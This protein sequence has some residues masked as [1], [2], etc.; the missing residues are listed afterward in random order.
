MTHTLT[1]LYSKEEL[2]SLQELHCSKTMHSVAEVTLLPGDFCQPL[3][4]AIDL[5]GNRTIAMP[6]MDNYPMRSLENAS[7]YIQELLAAGIEAVML[8]MDAPQIVGDTH[9]ILARQADVLRTLRGRFNPEVL[10]IIVDPFSVALNS[11]KTWG[12]QTGGKLDY[13]ATAELFAELTQTFAAAGA[14]YVLTLGRFEREADVAARSIKA[15]SATS[16]VSSFSTNT[17]TTNAYVYADHG[18]YAMT[19]QKILVSNSSEMVLRALVDIYEGSRMVI[20]KPAEN[21]HILERIT[22]L[23][24]SPAAL[25]AF[26]R[27]SEVDACA[28]I[29]PYVQ[30]VR[31]QILED[32]DRFAAIATQARLGAYTVSGTYFM[33][34]QTL[35]RKG[36]AFLAS[37]LYERFCN[38]KSVLRQRAD[39]GLIIDR[40]AHWYCTHRVV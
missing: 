14:S 13:I 2:A 31:M 20:V 26:L 5:P 33:D 30:R 17:E 22:R 36:T 8:R 10:T 7:G 6:N 39:N 4:I 3:D 37:V 1:D 9:A 23:L 35:A 18:A 12:V 32:I 15:T 27:S 29:S 24:Y 11:D 25:E 21:L 40:N 16:L 19:K 34:T 38:I 28:G